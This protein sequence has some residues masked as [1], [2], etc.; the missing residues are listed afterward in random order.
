MSVMA[1]FAAMLA[2]PNLPIAP[3]VVNALASFMCVA[4]PPESRSGHKADMIA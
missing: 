1:V 2:Y 3:G 4:V